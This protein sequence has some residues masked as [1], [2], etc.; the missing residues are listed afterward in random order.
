MGTRREELPYVRNNH[1][2]VK[3]TSFKS[4][5]RAIEIFTY[6]WGTNHFYLA[7]SKSLKRNKIFFLLFSNFKMNIKRTLKN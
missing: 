7:N 2:S 4:Y 5:K 6:N 3:E 1:Q